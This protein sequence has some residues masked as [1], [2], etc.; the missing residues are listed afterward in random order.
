MGIQ[1]LRPLVGDHEVNLKISEIIDALE[2]QGAVV[3]P[4]PP[5]G[6]GTHTLKSVGGELVWIEDEVL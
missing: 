1:K 3:V 2:A 4:A 5:T 6:Q